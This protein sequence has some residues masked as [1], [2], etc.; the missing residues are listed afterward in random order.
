MSTAVLSIHVRNKAMV[1][2]KSFVGA[3]TV[4]VGFAATIALPAT[5]HAT[6]NEY[7]FQSPSG[8]IGC[9][10]ID[11]GNG[12]VGAV[13]KVRDRTWVAPPPGGGRWCQ[14]A[15]TDLKLFQG[16]TPCV[17][18]WPNQIWLLQDWNELATLAYGQTHTIGTITCDSEPSGVTCTD[19]STGHYFRVSRESYQLG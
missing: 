16:E 4:A 10:M 14:Y 1:S 17:G 18:V 9:E 15:G 6:V 2:A 13:C 8:N 7:Q 12:T 3:A 11:E 19:S 5:A